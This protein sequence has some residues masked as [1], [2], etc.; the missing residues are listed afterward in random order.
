MDGNNCWCAVNLCMGI[1]LY[2]QIFNKRVKHI[3]ESFLLLLNMSSLCVCV[4]IWCVCVCVCVC[5]TLYL[6]STRHEPSLFVDG[7][8]I[9]SNSQLRPP[10][11]WQNLIDWP[12]GGDRLKGN[13]LDIKYTRVWCGEW[14]TRLTDRCWSHGTL[15]DIRA[16]K[17]RT[18]SSLLFLN[19]RQRGTHHHHHRYL[20][21]LIWMY[22]V[23]CW[24][25]RCRIQTTAFSRQGHAH[26]EAGL[27]LASSSAVGW[28]N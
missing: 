12:V 13:L 11:K 28:F 7:E 3:M 17:F 16:V 22:R 25:L 27:L 9:L 20:Y 4:C 5:V 18:V 10:D 15:V 21:M 2:Q 24:P 6:S 26:K 1:K 19:G 23:V 8:T 14:W